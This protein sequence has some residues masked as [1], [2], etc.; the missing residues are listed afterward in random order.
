LESAIFSEVG[1][2]KHRKESQWGAFITLLIR[3]GE[4]PFVSPQ[5]G[6]PHHCACTL[7]RRGWAG[8]V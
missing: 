2:Q 8:D 6:S 5:R 1:N 4:Y 3:P 7:G